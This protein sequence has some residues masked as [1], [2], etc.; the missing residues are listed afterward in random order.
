[1]HQKQNKLVV[2]TGGTRGIGR[3]IV[4]Q[5]LDSG[6][7]VAFTYQQSDQVAAD[8]TRQ[9]ESSGQLACGYRCNTS[10]AAEVEV[11]ASAVLDRHG[12]PYAIVNNVGITRDAL[13]IHMSADQWTQVVD[14]NLN[15]SFYVNQCFLPKMLEQKNGVIVHMSSVSGL[16]G[17]RGQSNYAATKAALI[18]FTRALASETARFNVRVNAL[19]PG[20]IDTE[21]VQAMPSAKLG[22]ILK[23]IPMGRLG[24]V[25]EV[26]GLVDFLLS[27]KATYITGQTFVVDGGLSM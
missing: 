14:A 22:M 9:A 1:M 15:S 24:R 18:G 23:H 11:F 26:A 10:S 17:N 16:R 5:L 12:P 20:L 25:D 7:D 6:Y 21:M 8:M 2:V 19:A 3:G 27:D 13:L 4:E